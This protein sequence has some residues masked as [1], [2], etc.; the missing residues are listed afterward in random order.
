ME[1]GV[2][3]DVEELSLPADG[4]GSVDEEGSLVLGVERFG[5]VAER[6]EGGEVGVV[7][8]DEADVFGVVVR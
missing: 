8:W 4:G 5:V 1:G 3:D 6:V 7:G 2:G